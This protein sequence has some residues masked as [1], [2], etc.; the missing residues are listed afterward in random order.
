VLAEIN[1][2]ATEANAPGVNRSQHHPSESTRPVANAAPP[3]RS[4]T[5]NWHLFLLLNKKS[6][7]GGIQNFLRGPVSHPLAMPVSQ[8]AR[9]EKFKIL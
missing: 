7:G 1:T 4:Y 5:T 3:P 6:F 9:A 2:A 8:S